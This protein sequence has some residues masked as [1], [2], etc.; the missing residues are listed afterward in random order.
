MR[1]KTVPGLVMSFLLVTMPVL[2]EAQDER[3]A[4][5]ARENEQREA[6]RNG[7][8]AVVD[9]VNTGS[10]GVLVGAIDEDAMLE[11]IFGL[12]LIDQQVKKQFRDSYEERLPMMIEQSITQQQQS[13]VKARLLGF[14][15]RGNQ[16][17]AVVR[18]DLENFQFAYHEYELTL[19]KR[20]GLVIVDWTDFFW[21]ERFSDAVGESLVIA[22][23]SDS[24]VRKLADFQNITANQIFKL[25]EALKAM[26][27]FQVARYF[28]IVEGMDDELKRQRIVVHGGVQMT[29]RA[30]ARRQLRT[31][32]IAL[33][34]Y[35]ANDPLYTNLLLDYY[36]PT[37]RYEDA[38]DSLQ[39]LSARLGVEDAAME[40][41]LSSAELVMRN[42]ETAVQHAER[43]LELEP[44]LELG[45]WSALRAR[46]AARDFG[47]AVAALT[48]LED[49][50]G[51]TLDREALGKDKSLARFLES[52]EYKEWLASRSK[53]SG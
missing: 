5:I 32:L 23:P 26:L 14:R 18:Y 13:P 10:F 29:K 24:A 38:R 44:D 11:K 39:R 49:E 45:W 15:S 43:A 6:M 47:A 9:A 36:F 27:D 28:E 4:A 2:V 12:R 53:A 1:S 7:I 42:T 33:D 30:R 19:D 35:F 40:A 17:L 25:G 8:A 16:G 3:D 50:F 41:R 51:Y 21:G 48:T 37:R 52:D 31:A 22:A 20:D 34:R 46:N